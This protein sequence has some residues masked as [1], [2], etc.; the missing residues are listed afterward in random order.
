MN[1][2]LS[3]IILL[4]DSI[5]RTDYEYLFD[6]Q[7]EASPVIAVGSNEQFGQF[8]QMFQ[9]ELTT[10]KCTHVD[11]EESDHSKLFY[12]TIITP[13]WVVAS[14]YEL[15]ADN[16]FEHTRA[17]LSK[18]PPSSSQLLYLLG[19]LSGRD[20]KVQYSQQITPELSRTLRLNQLFDTTAWFHPLIKVVF[21]TEHCAQYSLFPGS[22]GSFFVQ[23]NT[24]VVEYLASLYTACNYTEPETQY[25]PAPFLIPSITEP[26]KEDLTRVR[27][28]IILKEQVWQK[29]TWSKV[30]WKSLYFS[31]KYEHLA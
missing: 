31:K 9:S 14:P 20:T 15:W 17:S 8:F 26:S 16:F 27:A 25:F 4:T 2:V 11:P 1:A 23:Y 12:N 19:F 30:Y 28:Q 13:Y 10:R 22:G 29:N 7:W 6:L 21:N 3:T 5:V 18:I 24:L